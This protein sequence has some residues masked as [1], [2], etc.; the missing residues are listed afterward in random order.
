M[1]K[2]QAI[3]LI[4]YRINTA[5]EIAGKGEDGKSFEDLEMAVKALEEL[6]LYEENDLCL[7]PSDVYEKQCEELGRLKAKERL[8]RNTSVED[9]SII[10]V[11]F[12]PND[13]DMISVMRRKGNDTYVINVLTDEEAREVYNKLIGETNE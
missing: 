5:T 3:N 7:I 12:S 8:R 1:T 6:N 13:K 2:E 10:G 4:R 9:R 11:D